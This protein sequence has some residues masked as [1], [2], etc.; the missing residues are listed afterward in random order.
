MRLRGNDVDHA[1]ADPEVADALEE[2]IS[3]RW[4]RE[5]VS[6]AEIPQF[7]EFQP[8][9]TYVP[10]PGGYAVIF[11][12]EGRLAV[13]ATAEGLHLPGGGLEAGESA[14]RATMREVAEETGLRVEI[15]AFI[16][17]A[18]ELV[19]A[20]QENVHY[21]KRCS[22]FRATIVATG[23][24]S[25]PDHELKWMAPAEA[26]RTLHHEIQRWAVRKALETLESRRSAEE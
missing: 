12:P 9:A 15:R 14:E 26:L 23:E 21:R 3:R 20:L 5:V 7:G 17:V 16:G 11:D 8:G 10:R 13:V 22:F 6:V 25:E 24:P 18:H 1:Q 19:F 2:R 4:T